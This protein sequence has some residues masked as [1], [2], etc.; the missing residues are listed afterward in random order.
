M[1]REP[2][3]LEK[4]VFAPLVLREL[5]DELRVACPNAAEADD[6]EERDEEEEER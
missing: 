2:L 3:T 1:G 5:I 6:E 4:L